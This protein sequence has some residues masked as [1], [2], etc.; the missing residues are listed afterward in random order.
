MAL[1]P[2]PFLHSSVQAV[3][4]GQFA[5][6]TSPWG[7][8]DSIL[9]SLLPSDPETLRA[10]IG[11]MIGLYVPSLAFL[12]GW[13]HLHYK[14]R[15]ETA[16]QRVKYA[17]EQLADCKTKLQEAQPGALVAQ[18]TDAKALGELLTQEYTGKI[19]VLEE[20]KRV[21][22][23]EHHHALASVEHLTGQ[24]AEQTAE[25][26]RL[27]GEK[28]VAEARIAEL[29][30]FIAETH[31][32]AAG[33]QAAALRRAAREQHEYEQKKDTIRHRFVARTDAREEFERLHQQAVAERRISATTPEP[34]VRFVDNGTGHLHTIVDVVG[35]DWYIFFSEQ[36][37]WLYFN[38][39]ADDYISPAVEKWCKANERIRSDNRGRD[40][41]VHRVF[42]RDF[43]EIHIEDHE[44]VRHSLAVLATIKGGYPTPMAH[45]L[46]G[47]GQE[48][49]RGFQVWRKE[50]G[51]GLSY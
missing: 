16:D 33:I 19:A 48:V 23:A 49:E 2:A 20:E 10:I 18:I 3:G 34:V 15:I 40:V 22:E 50:H 17:N 9:S 29:Q 26:A 41:G 8:L 6:A 14:G 47:S 31:R 1:L 39:V 11:W 36:K 21:I 37:E 30:G 7:P 45:Y 35:H 27:D 28:A 12:T 42:G 24:T 51:T 25:L 38:P 13:F 44:G 4:T 43:V 32:L 46:S 5:Y